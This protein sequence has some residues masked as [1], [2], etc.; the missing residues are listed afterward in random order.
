MYYAIKRSKKRIAGLADE[1]KLL[2]E[3][4]AHAV[5]RDQD[6]IVRYYSAWEEED[7]MLIQNEYC[8]QGSLADRLADNQRKGRS[9]PEDEI[10]TILEHAVSLGRLLWMDSIVRSHVLAFPVAFPVS[11]SFPFLS[12]FPSLL[13]LFAP[14]LLSTSC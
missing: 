7:H 10:I 5:L 9:F 14:L 6:H 1:K 12:P 8:D 4:F 3:V 13:I 2:G 11:L